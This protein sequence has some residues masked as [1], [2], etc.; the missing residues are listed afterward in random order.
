M[1]KNR[2]DLIDAEYCLNTD[3]AGVEIKDGALRIFSMEASEKV[4]ATFRL[5]ATNSGG[6]SSRPRPD[7]AIYSLAA[8]LGRVAAY[9]FPV[10][11]NEVS[12][13][14]LE[15]QAAFES[16]ERAADMRLVARENGASTPAGEAA[17]AR[18]S[19][20]P[21]LNALLRTTCVATMLEGGH[22]ENA[23]PQRARATVNCRM[24][25]NDAPADVQRTLERLAGDSV[26]IAVTYP[27]V[28]S[29][30]SPLRADLMSAVER[31]AAKYFPGATLV[32]SMA[33]GASDG[34]Y[35]RNA[36]IPAYA[37]SAVASISGEDNSHG[38]DEK[39]RARGL[40][41]ATQYWYELVRTMAGG[42][43]NGDAAGSGRAVP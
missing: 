11:L 3:G 9:V 19:R 15:R 31:L 25:P 26:A 21:D 7:N 36:G 4:Y 17:V 38:R 5:E 41:Q 14:Q 34:L 40:Y 23:L 30:A 33:L 16:R 13:A 42:A 2:R 29:D 32:P 8:A 18:L 6:H 20:D 37:L 43:K 1:V 39:V 27:P 28:P 35:L 22:A 12:R 24:L 10:K